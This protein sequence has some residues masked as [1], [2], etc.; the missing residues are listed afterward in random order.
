MK[1][2]I[3]PAATALLAWSALACS[4]D[5]GFTPPDPDLFVVQAYLFAGQPVTEVRVTG[6]L[7]IDAEEDEVA[8]PITAAVVALTKGAD[9]YELV[10]TPGDPGAYQD[11]TGSIVVASGDVFEL[12]VVVDDRVA[13]A[14]TTVPVPPL[15]LGL[16][17][18]SLIAIDVSI[19]GRQG[20]QQNLLMVTWANPTAALHFLAVEG[21]D[22]DAAV[23]PS[24]PQGGTPGGRF[25]SAPTAAD[26]AFISQLTL[27]HFGPQRVLLYRVNEEYAN[28]YEGLVQDSRDLNEPPSNVEGALGVFTAFAADSAFF[29][30]R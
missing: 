30:V 17:S 1:R 5:L 25:V 14:E 28:L 16:S 21:M 13:R 19:G 18:D 12:E 27:T 7:P 11:P 15:G 3:L 4:D 29:D 24:A 9:R 8:P 20:F 26:S 22:P 10:P 6:V 23:L 2:S